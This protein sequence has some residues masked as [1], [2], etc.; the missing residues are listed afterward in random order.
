M[1][2]I[3]Q[4]IALA[5]CLPLLAA[6][7]PVE[8]FFRPAEFSLPQL[9]PDGTHIAFVAHQGW[10]GAIGVLNLA[11]K[12]M[13][14]IEAAKK[15]SVGWLT[16]ASNERIVF[17]VQLQTDTGTSSGLYDL[18]G[19]Y[20]VGRDGSNPKELV[21]SITRQIRGGRDGG[22]GLNGSLIPRFLHPL[23]QDPD[24][25]LVSFN[26]MVP[27]DRNG[28][29]VRLK[30]GDS[31]G[32][33]LV[34]VHT[35][36]RDLVE[37][38]FAHVQ[39]WGTDNAGKVRLGYSVEDDRTE[40]FHRGVG[41]KE[42][43]KI[44]TW[45]ITDP[46]FD[47]LGFDAIAGKL[48]VASNQGR[49]TTA[50]YSFD[51]DTR[52]LGAP[53]LASD[54]FD[55]DNASLRFDPVSNQL[56]GVEYEAEKTV[57]HAVNDAAAQTQKRLQ[58]AL[59][60]LQPS[61]VSQSLDGRIAL[62]EASSDRRPSVYFLYERDA[63]KL[64]M[65]GSSRSW[66]KTSDLS[67]MKPISFAARDGFK[68]RGYLTLPAGNAGSKPPLVV[69]PHGGPW[70]RDYWGFDP[71]VQ[72]L[73]NRGYA[74]L[75]VNFRGSAGFGRKFLEAGYQEWG[76]AMQD[77]VTDAVKWVIAEG[78]VDADRVGIYGASY[79]GF[80][81]MAGLCFTPEL[82]RCGV[83]VCGVTDMRT[84]MQNIPD[85]K[86]L[87]RANMERL[88]GD[89]KED[90]ELL[91]RRSP[92]HNVERIAVPVLLAY[93]QEDTVVEIK[94]GDRFHRELKRNGKE[95]KYLVFPDEGHGFF[96]RENQLKFYGE[97]EQFLDRHLKSA[98]PRKP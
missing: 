93:G 16:W 78:S 37:P 53:I 15:E 90:S 95:V 79:G 72:F 54:D 48:Y 58:Q 44:Y 87:L 17:R 11:T 84:F 1:K 38:V 40:F 25:V 21:P 32:V 92:Q 56:L 52:E 22:K 43:T 26:R 66:L 91:K 23:P 29:S 55:L 51:A 30:R 82:Y 74:V 62:V 85:E 20:A 46:D 19:L 41:S 76:A 12:K 45:Q 24:H 39:G 71:E 27:R 7:V 34:N 36:S 61:I 89:P 8:D 4:L 10:S 68:V 77:D 65:I 9:S 13:S 5:V 18:G 98:P 96:R 42:W 63:K 28:V 73:A 67:P 94:Q 97:L 86:K 57:F 88:V 2:P 3:A 64:S 70:V 81:A 6:N 80:A 60:D 75:Q 14:L 50:L 47:V 31:L 59:P 33:Y 69:L 35:G 83:N 49:D